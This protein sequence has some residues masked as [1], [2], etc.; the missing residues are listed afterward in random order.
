MKKLLGIVVLGLLLSGCAST[1]L[2]EY[3]YETGGQLSSHS[4]S[5]WTDE[6]VLAPP[7]EMSEDGSVTSTYRHPL[8]IGNGE[9]Y[10]RLK[11]ISE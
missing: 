9:A 8:S 4:V 10:L 7:E 2:L 1:L 11:A 6:G 5:G 3:R